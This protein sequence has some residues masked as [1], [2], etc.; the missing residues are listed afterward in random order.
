MGRSTHRPTATD[1]DIP[2]HI[3]SGWPPT[4]FSVIHPIGAFPGRIGIP[5]VQTDVTTDTTITTRRQCLGSGKRCRWFAMDEPAAILF[6][7]LTIALSSNAHC[8][9]A[10]EFRYNQ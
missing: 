7:A 2:V 5:T 4:Q 9:P 10:S 6:A 8:S 3:Q 1:T